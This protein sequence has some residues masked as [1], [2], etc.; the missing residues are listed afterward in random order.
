MKKKLLIML[1][2]TSFWS[3]TSSKKKFLIRM[4]T[5]NKMSSNMEEEVGRIAHPAS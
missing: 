4:Q 5:T 1:A 2:P 3:M